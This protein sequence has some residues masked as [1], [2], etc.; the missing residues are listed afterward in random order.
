ME[1]IGEIPLDSTIFDIDSPNWE[2]ELAGMINGRDVRRVMREDFSLSGV[3]FFPPCVFVTFSLKIAIFPFQAPS[4]SLG[5][6]V[7]LLAWVGAFWVELLGILR[8]S[9]RELCL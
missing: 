2:V 9:A 6:P 7:P 8:L 1:K 5:S 3:S 4:P